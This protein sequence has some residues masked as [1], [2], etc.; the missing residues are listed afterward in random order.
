MLHRRNPAMQKGRNPD[1]SGL[2]HRGDTA[3]SYVSAAQKR[4][5]R[6]QASV[7]ASVEVA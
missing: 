7:N 2:L 6:V 4:W 3:V 1:G 5:M